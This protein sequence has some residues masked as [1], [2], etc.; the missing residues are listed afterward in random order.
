MS[1]FILEYEVCTILFV[2][3]FW[4]AKWDYNLRHFYKQIWKLNTQGTKFG[5][6]D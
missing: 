1:F 5:K 3:S 6:L 4:L 2:L